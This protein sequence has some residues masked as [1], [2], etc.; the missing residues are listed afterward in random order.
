MRNKA[1]AIARYLEHVEEIKAAIPADRLLI[2][3]VDQGWGP[4]CRFLH[5][6][7][8]QVAFPKVND[9]AEIKKR[10]PISPKEPMSFWLL[11]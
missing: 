6:E 9:R 5:V 10:L 2:F 4:L 3:T 11:G 8:P 1:A 7:V